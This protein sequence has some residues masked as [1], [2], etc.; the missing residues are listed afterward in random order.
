[1]SYSQMSEYPCQ[2]GGLRV[3][4]RT[5]S[6]MAPPNEANSDFG[7]DWKQQQVRFGVREFFSG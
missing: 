3:E 5:L 2:Q 6:I 4:P 1:M 7:N